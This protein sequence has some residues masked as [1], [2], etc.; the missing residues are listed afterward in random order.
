M[1]TRRVGPK[2]EAWGTEP[3][4]EKQIKFARHLGIKFKKDI[5][6]AEMSRLISE[7]TGK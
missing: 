6:K 1:A 4:T 3:A 7:V 5:S 2:A